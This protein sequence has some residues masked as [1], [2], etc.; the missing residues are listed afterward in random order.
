MEA[1][2]R[3]AVA[4]F[5]ATGESSSA[6]LDG[7]KHACRKLC[8]MESGKQHGSGEAEKANLGQGATV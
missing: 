7:M 3:T 6:S 4:D 8:W 2:Q 1:S 5:G